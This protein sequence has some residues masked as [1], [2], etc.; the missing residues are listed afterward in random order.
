MESFDLPSTGR[1][2]LRRSSLAKMTHVVKYSVQKR[3]IKGFLKMKQCLVRD[4]QT[5][6]GDVRQCD[7]L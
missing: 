2:F 1:F 7:C 4:E 6:V 5:L 3:Q